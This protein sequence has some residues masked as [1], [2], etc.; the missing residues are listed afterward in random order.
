MA[1]TPWVGLVQRSKSA[2][3][4]MGTHTLQTTATPRSRRLCVMATAA[5][6]CLLGVLLV[7]VAGTTARTY[8]IHRH[9]Y[10]VASNACL[11][12]HLATASAH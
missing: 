6:C 11:R 7:L 5:S 4:Q 12:W 2:S 10:I 3:M 9:H 1:T 8:S